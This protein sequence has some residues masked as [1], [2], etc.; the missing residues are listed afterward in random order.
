MP[1]APEELLARIRFVVLLAGDRVWYPV[2]KK[3]TPA[4]D[5]RGEDNLLGAGFVNTG[6]RQDLPQ[7]VAIAQ[8]RGALRHFAAHAGG[9][10]GVGRHFVVNADETHPK[11]LGPVADLWPWEFGARNDAVDDFVNDEVFAR[12]MPV[13]R[14]RG[15]PELGAQCPDSQ[16]VDTGA[17]G[18]TISGIYDLLS[19]YCSRSHA[20]I[21]SRSAG[22][23]QANGSGCYG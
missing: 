3:V 19:R 22:A 16:R 10:S 6:N 15:H 2:S 7:I 18:D 12:E 14:R 1:Q 11:S 9:Q 17:S 5:E 23:L 8:R 4:V 13:D 21:L 20:T